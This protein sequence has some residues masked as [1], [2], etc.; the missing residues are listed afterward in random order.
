MRRSGRSSIALTCAVIIACTAGAVSAD[1]EAVG[2][3]A[4]DP[5]PASALTATLQGSQLLVSWTHSPG[6]LMA[7]TIDVQEAATGD[8]TASPVV[9][10]DAT[11]ATLD[12]GD[13]GLLGGYSY[14]ISVVSTSSGSAP[15]QT[16]ARSD[17]VEVTVPEVASATPAD[18]P[19]CSIDAL[20]RLL[21]IAV[22][23]TDSNDVFGSHT[24]TGR[25]VSVWKNSTR[26]TTLTVPGSAAGDATVTVPYDPRLGAKSTSYS[27]SY[28]VGSAV[29]SS[30][31]TG[32]CRV[33]LT[34][35]TP[36]AFVVTSKRKGGTVSVTWARAK[37][38][39]SPMAGYAVSWRLDGA[40]MRTRSVT[41]DAKRLFAVRV[42]SAKRVRVDVVA[43]NDLGGRTR[44]VVS[45]QKSGTRWVQ[46][47]TR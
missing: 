26:W 27:A 17:S 12:I 9:A 10:P 34:T 24:I 47:A 35:P 23:A 15:G 7:Q 33:T 13:T 3:S 5:N 28:I 8:S 37:S 45:W 29:G 44:R 25:T 21:T 22:P 11:S 14:L 2:A 42:G 18:G 20:S 38:A 1:A 30:G 46:G 16:P 6:V 32:R 40:P 36:N 4:A 39:I 31:S 41:A 43:V 19:T